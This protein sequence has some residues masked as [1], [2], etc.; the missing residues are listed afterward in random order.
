MRDHN[1][2]AIFPLRVTWRKTEERYWL[3]VSTLIQIKSRPLS[4]FHW[5]SVL[6]SLARTQLNS[7]TCARGIWGCIFFPKGCQAPNRFLREWWHSQGWAPGEFRQHSQAQGGVVKVSGT[8]P[9]LSSMILMCAFQLRIV[10]DSKKSVAKIAMHYGVSISSW[11][12]SGLLFFDQ[13]VLNST[14]VNF[15]FFLMEDMACFPER[16]ISSCSYQVV[17]T[18]TTYSV[19]PKVTGVLGLM[20]RSW[21]YHQAHS[22]RSWPFCPRDQLNI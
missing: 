7:W 16:S 17:N 4:V 6:Q 22:H 19:H 5:D 18:I 21:W 8:G 13:S 2:T 3:V 15:N 11:F 10:C 20:R 1:G 12:F 9:G 14:I